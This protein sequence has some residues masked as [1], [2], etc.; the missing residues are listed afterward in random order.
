MAKRL[1][2]V[3]NFRLPEMDANGVA[4][5]VLSISTPGVQWLPPSETKRAVL[6]AAKFNDAMAEVVHAHPARFKAFATLP[7]Q[8]PEAAAKELERC[9]AQLGFVGA[10]VHG[11][12]NGEYLDDP[13]F[14]AVWERA[15]ALDAPIYLHPTDPIPDQIK[16]YDGHSELLGP[17]WNWGVETGTHALRIVFGGV[18]E[19]YPKA[20]LILGHMGE[21]LP[22]FL[23]RINVGTRMLPA[24]RARSKT[25]VGVGKRRHRDH[26]GRESLYV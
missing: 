12:T 6:Q 1:E 5:Q 17:A 2:D 23:P 11:H 10:M 21:M 15:E 18:F 13:K 8:D 20:T 25:S 9:V 16:I 22:Y 14:S 3:E 24:G 26:H 7:M 19:R 4:V